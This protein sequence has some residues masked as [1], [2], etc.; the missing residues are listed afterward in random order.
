MDQHQPG[1]SA[2]KRMAIFRARDAQRIDHEVM[3]FE[4][5]DESV[6][7]GFASLM[8]TGSNP[9]DD[10]IATLLYR[11]PGPQGLSL[12]YAW[13]KSGYV[14]PK[15]SHNADCLYYV[16]A[17]SLTMGSATLSKGDGVFIPAEQGYT[18]VVGPEGVEVLEFRNATEFH[19]RFKDNEP[20]HWAKMA[21]AMSS[22]AATWAHEP[23]PSAR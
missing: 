7:A 9:N 16:L 13:F 3:P 17:G 22:N 4:G 21:Q 5:V 2:P 18:Y 19:I 12:S 14:L 8:A 6:M 10:A 11:E 1:V 20:A 15:H 23:P